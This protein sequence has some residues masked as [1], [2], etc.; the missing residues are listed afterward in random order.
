MGGVKILSSGVLVAFRG[1]VLVHEIGDTDFGHCSE[2]RGFKGWSLLDLGGYSS[3]WGYRV[4]WSLFNGWLLLGGVNRG[5][6]IVY[7]L[8]CN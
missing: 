7:L 5:F 4:T 6:I 1:I 3:T 8:C 2:F